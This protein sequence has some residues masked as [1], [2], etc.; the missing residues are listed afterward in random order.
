MARRGNWKLRVQVSCLSRDTPEA[1]LRELHRHI[2]KAA[3]HTTLLG[4]QSE[5]DIMNLFPADLMQYGA[6]EEIDVEIRSRQPADTGALV[7]FS[8]KVHELISLLITPR[9]IGIDL[10]DQ[11]GARIEVW[12]HLGGN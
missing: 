12:R 6:G 11:N 9:T 2:V 7:D 5:S 4:V 10:F 1:L 3:R 8:R